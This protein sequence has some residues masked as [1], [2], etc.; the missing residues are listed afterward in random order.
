MLRVVYGV[1]KGVRHITDISADRAYRHLKKR[2][3]SE[4]RQEKVRAIA[5]EMWYLHPSCQCVS[6][7]M[8]GGAKH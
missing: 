1:L 8:G 5:A 4:T 7:F 2:T 6:V 3:K